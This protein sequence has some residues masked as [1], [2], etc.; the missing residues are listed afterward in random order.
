MPM[1][2]QSLDACVFCFESSLYFKQLSIRR[3]RKE[4]RRKKIKWISPGVLLFISISLSRC[5]FLQKRARACNAFRISYRSVDLSEK[6]RTSSRSI[7]LGQ[8]FFSLDSCNEVIWLIVAFVLE[9]FSSAERKSRTFVCHVPKRKQWIMI[10]S[11]R[12]ITSRRRRSWI[13][14]NA[15]SFFFLFVDRS[16]VLRREEVFHFL[17]RTNVY[18]MRMIRIE[19]IKDSMEFTRLEGTEREKEMMMMLRR[20]QTR[21]DSLVNGRSKISWMTNRLALP[22]KKTTS[23][24]RDALFVLR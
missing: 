22:A 23:V 11:L 24:P 5:R 20:S 18:W 8:L 3:W 21:K 17:S 6:E 2:S 16:L 7:E 10:K 12:T 4:R 1:S 9:I 14:R 19:I 15:R 13:A